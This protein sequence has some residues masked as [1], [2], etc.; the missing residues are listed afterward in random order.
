MRTLLVVLALGT[1]AA[2]RAAS[3]S[4]CLGAD[5]LGTPLLERVRHIASSADAKMVAY[6]R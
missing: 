1:A 6:R 5:S 3:Q 2:R 4:V